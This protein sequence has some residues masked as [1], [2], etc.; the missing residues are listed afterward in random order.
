MTLNPKPSRSHSSKSSDHVPQYLQY[1]T[2]TSDSSIFAPSATNVQ[3]GFR[4]AELLPASN[5]GSDPSTVG[6]KTLHFSLLKDTSRPLNLSHEYQI[7][8]LESADYSTN[9]IALKTG[10]IIGTNTTADRDMLQLFGNVNAVPLQT[11]FKTKFTPGTWHNFGV[12]LDF[13]KLLAHPDHFVPLCPA[14]KNHVN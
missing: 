2:G 10:Q 9:Q 3:L 11:L 6:V 14:R 7:V 1:L 5:N 13:N 8:F 12:I 4:R